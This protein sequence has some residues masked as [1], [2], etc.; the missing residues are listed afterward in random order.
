MA[1]ADAYVSDGAAAGTNYGTATLLAARKAGTGLNRLSYLTFDL[2]N[3]STV[4]SV[5]L[6]LYG[7]ITA[8]GSMTVNVMSVADT[9]WS[10]STLT[11][12]NRP[13][14]GAAVGSL[15]VNSTT[16]G[17]VEMDLTSYVRAQLAAGKKLVSLALT[18]PV[19]SSFYAF[20]NSRESGAKGPQL[21][22]SR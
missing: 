15:S 14:T 6:R 8:A 9:T 17:W 20:F 19:T 13:A 4:V 5:K 3:L 10:E 21:V 1:K 18:D 22:V 16:A 7:S 12:N 11:Y 2:S